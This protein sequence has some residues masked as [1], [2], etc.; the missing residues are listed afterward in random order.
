[1]M[2]IRVLERLL[3]VDHMTEIWIWKF[4]IFMLKLGSAVEICWKSETFDHVFLNN[5]LVL[6]IILGHIYI[7]WKLT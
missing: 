7:F 1:L 5:F 2:Q 3:V 4:E 6:S